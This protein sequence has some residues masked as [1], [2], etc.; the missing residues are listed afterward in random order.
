MGQSFQQLCS[1]NLDIH[2]QMNGVGPLPCTTLKKK[3]RLTQN[4]YKTKYNS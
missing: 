1:E 2:M 3:K 4:E